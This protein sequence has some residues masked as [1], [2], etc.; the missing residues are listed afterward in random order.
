M[1]TS[2]KKL[3]FYK[4]F[5][6]IN[7]SLGLN[8]WFGRGGL[9]FPKVMIIS[10]LVVC[11]Y[12]LQRSREAKWVI[13]KSVPQFCSLLSCFSFMPFSSADFFFSLILSIFQISS[14]GFH[15]STL[16]LLYPFVRAI[17]SMVVI[18]GIFSV[19]TLFF[20]TFLRLWWLLVLLWF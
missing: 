4:L 2:Q 5:T 16:V 7:H 11:K 19:S 12:L 15:S 13:N 17:S 8:S 20:Q 3:Q 18:V 14:S 6:T 9:S 10:S 1:I